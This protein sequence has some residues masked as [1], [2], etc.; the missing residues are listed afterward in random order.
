MDYFS[1]MRDLFAYSSIE[2]HFHDYGYECFLQA[3]ILKSG[4]QDGCSTFHCTYVAGHRCPHQSGYWCYLI[5]HQ[6]RS[7]IHLIK[8]WALQAARRSF[9]CYLCPLLE[10]SSSSSIEDLTSPR[11]LWRLICLN[12]CNWTCWHWDLKIYRGTQPDR[13]SR[14]R[15]QLS[16]LEYILH[17]AA[18]Y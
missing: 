14:R 1:N 8:S 11:S 16:Y 17:P 12:F 9:V 10:G 2:A 3:S 18:S 13:S 4:W 7:S 6:S 5:N 15:T